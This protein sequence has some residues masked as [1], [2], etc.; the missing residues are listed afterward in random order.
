V[1]FFDIDD[2]LLDY[3]TSQ[4][5]AAL[6]FAKKYANYIQSPE[7]F[8]GVWDQLTERHMARYLSGEISFQEQRRCRVIE[9]LGLTL[10]PQDADRIFDEY[11]QIY[12]A[13]WSL[14][15]DVE[16]TL[17][18]LTDFPL[19]V[20][21]NGDRDHQT[22]KLGKLGIL[23]YFTDVVTPACAGAAKPDIAI[24]K[25]AALRAGKL[26]SQCWY[27][28]DNHAADYQGAKSAG[29]KSVWLNR[30]G[31]QKDCENQCKDLYEFLLKVQE[32]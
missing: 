13:S 15:P 20:I 24:F 8:A 9:S 26:P 32:T 10:S 14:F 27:I 11:Y 5:K 28:G 4:D 18:K 17:E 3:K 30:L 22:Y 1:I 12:E 16:S 6:V 31:R 25:H 23:G 29:Y 2:T 19:A 7:D 21:T